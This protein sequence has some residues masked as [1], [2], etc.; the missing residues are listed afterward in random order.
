MT[1]FS[2]FQLS[3]TSHVHVR[4]QV[5]VWFVDHRQ[6]SGKQG[7]LRLT[8]HSQNF[9]PDSKLSHMKTTNK[10]SMSHMWKN[11]HLMHQKYIN[12]LYLIYN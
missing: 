2:V 8:Q 1:T 10:K 5:K 7:D 9:N 6:E 11:E 12:L 4:M 3:Y